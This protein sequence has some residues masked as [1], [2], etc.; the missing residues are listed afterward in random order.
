MPV[1]RARLPNL[2]KGSDPFG[3]FDC[4]QFNLPMGS[5][6]FGKFKGEVSC[7]SLFMLL[8]KSCYL[9]GK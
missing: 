9:A 7:L 2:P 8:I 4:A 1:S 3:K 5:D 6:P